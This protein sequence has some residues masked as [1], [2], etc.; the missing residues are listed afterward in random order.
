MTKPSPAIGTVAMVTA[1]NRHEEWRAVWLGHTWRAMDGPSFCVNVPV[2]RRDLAVID[3]QDYDLMDE[4][5]ELYQAQ[6]AFGCSAANAFA[7]AIAE[8]VRRAS[9]L[10]EP[11][12]FGAIVQDDD[13]LDWHRTRD[14]RWIAGN[15]LGTKAG[16][17]AHISK[18]TLISEGVLS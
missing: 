14:G 5:A 7:I 16:S 4:L 10:D 8:V 6:V 13:G 11:A 12:E 15:G 1:A 3:P 18:P 17:W 9:P 2:S